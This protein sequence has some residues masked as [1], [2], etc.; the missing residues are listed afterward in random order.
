VIAAGSPEKQFKT[1]QAKDS[2]KDRP[3][4]SGQVE[5]QLGFNPQNFVNT[6]VESK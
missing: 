6:T 1:I 5:S 4:T 3:M 2:R